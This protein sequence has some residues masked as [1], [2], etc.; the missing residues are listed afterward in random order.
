MT[1]TLVK[2]AR[3]PARKRL[4]VRRKR[5]AVAPKIEKLARRHAVAAVAALAAVMQDETATAA[6]RISAAG[7]ILQW[8]FGRPQLQG[9]ATNGEGEQVIRLT[10]GED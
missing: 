3:R 6:A 9:K 8:G 10:W 7:A 5:K 2:G 1:G 4:A